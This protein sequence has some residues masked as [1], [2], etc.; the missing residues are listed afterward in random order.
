MRVL[1]TGANGSLAPFVLRALWER[2]EAVLRSRWLPYSDFVTLPWIQGDITVFANCQRV[3]AGTAAMQHLAAHPWPVDHPPLRKQATAQGVPFDATFQSNM[4]GTPNLM[5]T[6]VAVRVKRVVM[7]GSHCA[8]EHGSRMSQTP[9]PLQVLPIDEG[10][11]V[12]PEDSYS[13]SK[14]AGALLLASSTRAYGIRT[15]ITRPAAI[16]FPA[17][18]QLLAHAHQLRMAGPR[19]LTPHEESYFTADDL[20]TLEPS[21]ALIAQWRP[22]LLPCADRLH[23]PQSFLSPQ[24]LTQAVGWQHQTSW[25]TLRS[26]GAWPS[27]HVRTAQ[28]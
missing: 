19:T 27:R 8:L 15:F 23:D 6:T 7:A 24:K 4:L 14:L 11:P 13:Y 12:Y 26:A 2:H 18:R 10:H 3:V 25:R 9:F 21:A 22:T 20:L 28:T 16:C 17:R 5:Q 1:L